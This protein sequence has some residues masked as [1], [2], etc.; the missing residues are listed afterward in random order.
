MPRYAERIALHEARVEDLSFVPTLK[1]S[2]LKERKGIAHRF[3]D[4]PRATR[5]SQLSAADAFG[6]DADANDAP[7]PARV[8]DAHGFGGARPRWDADRHLEKLRRY[9]NT[10]L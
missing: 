9:E 6:D 7:D 3:K 2:F 10:G 5:F 8:V 1:G 4:A